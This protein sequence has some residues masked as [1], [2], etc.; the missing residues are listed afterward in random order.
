M[1]NHTWLAV[2]CTTLFLVSSVHAQFTPGHIFV[3][4]Q[5]SEPC[6]IDFPEVI[7]EIDPTTG[8]MS[9]FADFDDGL[10][11]ATGL[12]FTPDGRRLLL[13]NYRRSGIG[14]WIQAFNPD[15]TSEVFLDGSDGIA[16][17]S[18]KNG[19]AFDAVGD[20]YVVDSGTSK[21]MR[22]PESTGPGVVFA[23][24]TDG[25][26][27]RG[28]LDFAPNGDLF[29]ASEPAETIIRINPDGVASVFDPD[30]PINI[31]TMAMDRAGN[32]FIGVGGGAILRYDNTDPTTLRF[33]ATGF[34]QGAMAL[35]VSPHQSVVYFA[36]RDGKVYSV[37]AKD[38]TTTLL[39]T[40]SELP[41]AIGSLHPTGMAVY[42]PYVIP[43]VSPWGVV[44]MGV[45]LLSSGIVVLR[46]RVRS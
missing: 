33:L 25:I 38:G 9:I 12:R 14:G 26:I 8:D 7:V 37:D 11:N 46:R 22:F 23:D 3:S 43:A 18:G 6:R 5:H 13:L 28:A 39:A 40:M 1:R 30:A 16:R 32:M 20:L 27:G 41:F 24:G 15:G 19:L 35:V 4:V 17:P 31:H 21:I 34:N 10:C 45:L 36:E 29:Y 42:A 44:A 2:L